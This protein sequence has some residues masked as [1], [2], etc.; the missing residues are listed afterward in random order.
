MVAGSATL[1]L[2]P[3][4]QAGIF[5]SSADEVS[6]LRL[7]FASSLYLLTTPIRHIVFAIWTIIV[8]SGFFRSTL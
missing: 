3:Q 1:F 4:N 5:V 7:N 2:L 6:C 8:L